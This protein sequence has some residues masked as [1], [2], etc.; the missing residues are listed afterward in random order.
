MGSIQQRMSEDLTLRNYAD[1]TSYQYLRNAEIFVDWICCSPYLVGEQKVRDYVLELLEEKS[2]ATAKIHIASIKF[3]VRGHAQEAEGRR[4]HPVAEGSAH[5]AGHLE[6]R[7]GT[8]SAPPAPP[9]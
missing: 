4:Q 2:P 9:A 5:A 7:A 3:P 6:L 1:G 8:R